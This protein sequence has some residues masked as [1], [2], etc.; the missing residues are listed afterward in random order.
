MHINKYFIIIIILQ[1]KK[2]LF[3]KIGLLKRMCTVFNEES[4][5]RVL[6]NS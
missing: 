4:F 6:Y 3:M 2:K 1:Y 5:L